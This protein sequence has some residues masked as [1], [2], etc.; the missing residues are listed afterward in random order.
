MVEDPIAT[1]QPLPQSAPAETGPAAS[2]PTSTE[3]PLSEDSP[4]AHAVTPPDERAEAA[5][6]AETAEAAE[7]GDPSERFPVLRP[8]DAYPIDAP[9]GGG[10]KLLALADPSGIAPKVMTLPPLGAAVIEL[11]DGSRTREQIC[12]DFADR[13]KRPLTAEALEALLTK[14]DDALLLDS[15]R[16]RL[17][18]ARLFVEY[19]ALPTR[20]PFSAGTRYPA[21]PV[22]LRQVLHEA[23]ARPNGPGLPLADAQE[24]AQEPAQEQ[25][26]KKPPAVPRALLVPTLD[27]SRCGPAYAWAYRAILEMPKLPS[28]IVLFACDHGAHDALV[29]LT[30]KHFSTPLGDLETDQELVDALIADCTAIAPELGELLTRDESHHRGEYSLEH[31]AVWLRYILD[32]RKAFRQTQH[33]ATSQGQADLPPEQ[34]PK[35]LPVLVGSLHDLAVHPPSRDGKL[36]PQ[37]TTRIFE[38]FASVLQTRI[39]QRQSHGEGILWIGAADLAHVGPRFGDPDPISDDDRDSLERRDLETF[40]PVL[41]GDRQGFL[42]EI[43]RERDRRRIQGLGTIY[44]LLAAANPGLGRLRCYAQVSVDKGSYISLATAQYP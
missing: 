43:R 12:K 23:F 13:Y 8:L 33:L 35:I 10:Q 15:T 18:C 38:T 24:S 26:N 42:A 4:Q 32:L 31:Q 29:T 30:K 20:P 37:Q 2:A 34:E 39:G 7:G 16:F 22:E 3:P 6:A 44:L 25:A 36:E 14:L 28:L 41:S 5:E 11:C 27:P 19:A 1:S 40:K 9:G 21:D 17:H